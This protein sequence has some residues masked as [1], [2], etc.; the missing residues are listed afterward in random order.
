[1]G[2]SQKIQDEVSINQ[3]FQS[4]LDQCQAKVSQRCKDEFGN[5]DDQVEKYYQGADMNT[6]S[7]GEK[8]NF[9]Q[10]H[11]TGI[12]H[13]Q[14]EVREA[15]ESL[16]GI[17]A[18][19]ETDDMTS[20]AA[21]A[22][23][24]ILSYKSAAIN[25][26]STV[27]VSA[28]KLLSSSIEIKF[29][30]QYTATALA[31]G[32]TLHLL[33]A[34]DSFSNER[35][36]DG[37]RIIE[38]YLRYALIFS[39]QKG[40]ADFGIAEFNKQ[41]AYISEARGDL[42]ALNAEILNGLKNHTMTLEEARGLRETASFMKDMLGEAE[43]DVQKMINDYMLKTPANEDGRTRALPMGREELAVVRDILS[44]YQN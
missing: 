11:D 19:G 26:A 41:N 16:F 9:R 17:A 38:S 8:W 43:V 5:F 18:T 15:L 37:E 13:I 1:M 20:E 23:G 2:K 40:Y 21:K 10:T 12:E 39:Y 32:L 25:V 3:E 29:D 33:V 7:K 35:F 6:L 30:H 28:M 22:F 34:N 4:Y 14:Q 24:T 31:P 42:L 36:L 27:I 44:D